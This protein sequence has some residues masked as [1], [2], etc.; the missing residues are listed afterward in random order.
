[1]TVSRPPQIG[2][3]KPSA[4]EQL[5]SSTM[6]IQDLP[7][8]VLTV[9]FRCLPIAE[10]H[11]IAQ[12]SRKMR[13]ITIELAKEHSV[14]ELTAFINHLIESLCA[15][16][17]VRRDVLKSLQAT[18]QSLQTELT[19]TFILP[20]YYVPRI[21]NRI[22]D[23]LGML[24]EAA[25]TTLEDKELLDGFKNVFLIDAFE[26]IFPICKLYRKALRVLQPMKQ[27]TR[28]FSFEWGLVTLALLGGMDQALRILSLIPNQ[29]LRNRQCLVISINLINNQQTDQAIRILNS[30]LNQSV[31]DYELN[32]LISIPIKTGNMNQAIQIANATSSDLFLIEGFRKIC[33]TIAKTK[34]I[35]E[36][37]QITSFARKQSIEK[38]GVKKIPIRKHLMVSGYLTEKT[39]SQQVLLRDY[40]RELF[41]KNS[42]NHLLCIDCINDELLKAGEIEKPFDAIAAAKAF[43]GATDRGFFSLGIQIIRYGF[44]SL[45]IEASP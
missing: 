44:S 19:G 37:I 40:I 14:A 35:D 39:P 23:A 31:R 15:I 8:D 42:K 22:I 7:D 18:Q 33:D 28:N 25:L 11:N 10:L 26:K 38:Y 34:G 29:I 6:N 5:S 3:F 20:H 43:K 45:E 17:E 12:T 13:S 24:D 2:E 1:M 16:P 27:S 41:S 21:K 9:I 36:A 30:I 32:Q 4:I